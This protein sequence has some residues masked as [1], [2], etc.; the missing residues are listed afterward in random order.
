MPE[1]RF[2]TILFRSLRLRCPMCGRGKLFRTWF[3]MHSHCDV[4]GIRFEREGGFFLGSIYFNYGL[5]ALIAAIAYPILLFNRIVSNQVA[6]AGVLAFSLIFPM[7]F[8]PLARSLWLG[9]DQ[10]WDPRD[11]DPLAAHADTIGERTDVE[12][13]GRGG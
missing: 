12:R 9:F 13:F 10:F 11:V 2:P 6:M 1:G 3:R 8:F 5:T 4:C 7:L